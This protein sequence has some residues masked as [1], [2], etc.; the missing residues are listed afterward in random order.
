MVQLIDDGILALLNKLEEFIF[1]VELLSLLLLVLFLG[2]LVLLF[3]RSVDSSTPSHSS[4]PG[5]DGKYAIVTDTWQKFSDVFVEPDVMQF[6]ANFAD[7]FLVHG[8]DVEGKKLGIDE[9][10]VALLGKHS[11]IPV[12]YAGGVTGMA[13]LERIKTAGMGRVDVTVGSALDIF[14]GNLAYEEV[15]A[16]HTQQKA[17]VG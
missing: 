5:N 1:S 10:L 9:E 6:L 17:S 14:G 15:V 11:P 8:V 16:W 13:D 7:E 3:F 4:D 2:D 12:T